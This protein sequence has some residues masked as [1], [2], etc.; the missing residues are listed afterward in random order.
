MGP[1]EFCTGIKSAGKGK[2][3]SSLKFRGILMANGRIALRV[4]R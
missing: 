1:P 3:R 2:G 4:W